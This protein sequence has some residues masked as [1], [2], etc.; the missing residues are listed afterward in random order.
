[1]TWHTKADNACYGLQ[2]LAGF[3]GI[4]LLLGAFASKLSIPFHIS[5]LNVID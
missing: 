5:E 2:V 4:C 3:H 1:M